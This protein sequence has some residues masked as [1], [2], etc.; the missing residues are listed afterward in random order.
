MFDR[1]LEK[2]LI[3]K[4]SSRMR[5]LTLKSAP[6]FALLGL[7][8]FASGAAA[9]IGRTKGPIDITADK[10]EVVD[11]QKVAL[12]SGAVEARQDGNTMR[13]DRMT[14]QFSGAKG[15]SSGSAMGKDWGEIRSLVAEGRV[16]FITPAEVARGERAV[17][18]VTLDQIRMT[19][20]VVVTRGQNV[21]K[22]DT[23]LIDVKSGRSTFDSSAKGRSAPTRVRGVFYPEKKAETPA[24]N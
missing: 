22:G 5:S 13:S 23:L 1:G 11:A 14:V 12:W 18:D 9:Q 21:L 19:G 8:V 4:H 20:G 2:T 17:Y 6:V 7:V 10:L 3:F 16:F 15:P 24:G